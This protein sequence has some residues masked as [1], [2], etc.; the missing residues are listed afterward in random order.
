MGLFPTVSAISNGG[1]L[2][3]DDPHVVIADLSTSVTTK[4]KKR[5]VANRGE[6]LPPDS[7]VLTIQDISS[8]RPT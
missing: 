6:R 4:L 5:F 7:G 2:K 3:H 8:I 1:C